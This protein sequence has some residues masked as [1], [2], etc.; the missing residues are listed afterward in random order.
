MADIKRI[1]A[2][3]VA[4]LAVIL[5]LICGMPAFADEYDSYYTAALS[6]YD[7]VL[8]DSEETELLSLMLETANDIECNVGVVITDDLGGESDHKYAANYYASSFPTGSSAVVFLFNN[9]K[10]SP[11]PNAD[12]LYTYGKGTDVFLPKSDKIL[13][14]IYDGFDSSGYYAAIKNFCKVLSRNDNGG[15]VSIDIE[16]FLMPAFI[17]LII[18]LVITLSVMGGITRGYKKK[19]PVSAIG[20][21]DQSRTRFTKKEDVFVREF[22]TSHRISSSSSGSHGGRSGGSGGSRGSHRSG[23]GGSRGRRR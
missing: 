9:D 23:G 16:S 20:Y 6:D 19:A 2:A 4:V 5:L 17:A 8:T 18:D 21:L 14:A 7:G 12:Y 22:T 11:P 13:N 10:S 1:R 3:I 15:S